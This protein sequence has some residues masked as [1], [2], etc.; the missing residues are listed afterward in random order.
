MNKVI[1]HADMDAF[2]AS[3]EQRDRG[4]VG[5]P[6]IVGSAP[7]QRGV[8]CAASY[9]ARKF[10]IRSAMPSRTA[11]KLCPNGIF[12]S[13]NLGRY[14]QVSTELMNIFLSYTPIIEKISVDEAFLD[15]TGSLKHFESPQ[16][17]AADLKQKVN[18]KLGLTI[19]V[20][21]APNKFLAKIASD[22]E[23]PNGLTTVP[24][25]QDQIT[26]FLRPLNIERIWGVGKITS[27]KLHSQCIYTVADIQDIHPTHLIQLMGRNSAVSL[28]KLAFGIDERSVGNEA[29]EKSLSNETTFKTDCSEPEII[30]DTLLKLVEKVC[31]RTRKAGYISKTM[32]LKIRF[33]DFSTI[34]R[35]QPVNQ[36]FISDRQMIKEAFKLLDQQSTT[37]SIRLI[38]FGLSSL[39]SKENF[40][41]AKTQLNFFELLEGDSSPQKSKKSRPELDKAVDKIRERLGNKSLKRGN[42]NR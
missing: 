42:W 13:P 40:Q 38:G 33:S 23:K 19:S 5:L 15:I 24:F 12:I 35:Q 27:K 6:V 16:A 11:G 31:H 20:G 9:E 36:E 4:L 7:D 25:Q 14:Q 34:T 8:V 32:Q 30:K 21:I 26:S 37:M 28:R 18:E 2:F 29:S 41:K 1:I 3:V 10:G 22:L 39:T 17:L